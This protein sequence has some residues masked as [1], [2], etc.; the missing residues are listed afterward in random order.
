MLRRAISLA[1]LIGLVTVG[2]SCARTQQDLPKRSLGDSRTHTIESVTSAVQKAGAAQGWEM[3]VIRPG[4]IEATKS[5]SND[6][7]NIVVHVVYDAS[8]YEIRYVGSKALS[9]GGGTIHGS[10]NQHAT[11]L[12]DEIKK[13]VS[14]AN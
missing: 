14:A 3:K 1:L 9:A 12:Y 4:L 5:W 6:K 8:E 10:Y 11:R 2:T 7:H 13:Q